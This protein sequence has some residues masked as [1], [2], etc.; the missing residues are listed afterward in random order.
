M[1]FSCASAL[2]TIVGS[3]AV[4]PRGGDTE[5]TKSKSRKR[6]ERVMRNAVLKSKDASAELLSMLNK[7]SATGIIKE[8]PCEGVENA[9]GMFAILQNIS[10]R[11]QGIECALACGRPHAPWPNLS[12][13]VPGEVLDQQ[14]KS[15]RKIQRWLRKMSAR[16]QVHRP[17]DPVVDPSEVE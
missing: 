11:L 12:G 4:C 1:A 14:C 7:R 17:L 10:Q 2:V 6:K 5:N 16:A 8:I 13:S 3:S 15:A 9:A